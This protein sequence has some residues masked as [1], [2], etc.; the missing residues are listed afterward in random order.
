M[1]L[2]RDVKTALIM[3]PGHATLCM[4]AELHPHYPMEMGIGEQEISPSRNLPLCLKAYKLYV[5]KKKKQTN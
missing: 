3:V 4:T 5:K 1:G 2:P